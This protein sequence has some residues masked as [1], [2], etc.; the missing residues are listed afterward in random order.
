M[1]SEILYAVEVFPEPDG[2]EIS[3]TGC[4]ARRSF[5]KSQSCSKLVSKHCSDSN[6]KFSGFFDIERFIMSVFI[7]LI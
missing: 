7:K 5:I 6:I 1:I 2:P 4:V 3:T